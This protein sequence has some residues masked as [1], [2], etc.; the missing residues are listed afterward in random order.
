MSTDDLL[1]LSLVLGA[2]AFVEAVAGFGGTVLALS[3]GARWFGIEALL[4]WFLPLNLGLSVALALRGRRAIAW[5]AL[6]VAILPMILAGLAA[7]T[8]LA[9]VVDAERA[10]A[11]FAG[12]VIVV[13]LLELGAHV[14]ARGAAAAPTSLPP[15]AQRG[16]LLGA[17]VVHGLFATGGPLAVAV[18]ARNLTSKAALRATLAVMWLVLNVIV[19]SRLAVRGHLH[20]DSLTTSLTLV[21]AM[22]VGMLL[23]DRVHARVSE[24]AF[25]GAVAGLL[26]VTGALLLHAALA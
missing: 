9:W 20:A 6:G 8:A 3:L 21:P 25:R 26:L 23:G 16:L 19:L 15:A 17:G 22:A 14:R 10:R 11:L 4:A 5:R 24:R 12:L 2:G 1:L 7:G 18:I 13:A